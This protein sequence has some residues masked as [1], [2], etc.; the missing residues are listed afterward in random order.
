MCFSAAAGPGGVQKDHIH[1]ACQ[2]G[3]ITD[4][5]SRSAARLEGCWRSSCRASPIQ[6]ASILIPETLIIHRLAL[7]YPLDKV[8][9]PNADASS[10]K[11][12]PQVEKWDADVDRAATSVNAARWHTHL[13]SEANNKDKK[14]SATAFQSTAAPSSRRC[15]HPVRRCPWHLRYFCSTAVWRA[16][17]SYLNPDMSFFQVWPLHHQPRPRLWASAAL[18][19]ITI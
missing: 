12:C 11:T 7:Q 9:L 2:L 6:K 13:P 3:D 14:H 1:D 15:V 5:E 4:P 10:S 17:V 18:I 16:R 8:F 19:I